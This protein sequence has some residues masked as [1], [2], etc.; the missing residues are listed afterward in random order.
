MLLDVWRTVESCPRVRPIL[1]TTL[2]GEFAI[3]I[4]PDDI[5][6]QG[7]GALGDRLE[8]IFHRGLLR[9][10][11]VIAVGADSPALT[12]AHLK[13]ALEALQTKDSVVGPSTDGGFYLLGLRSLPNGLFDSLPWSCSQ[14][15]EALK[16]RIVKHHLSMEE[17]D[18]LFDVDT[19][20]DLVTLEKHL[21]RHPGLA[22]ATRA[23]RRRNQRRVVL[24]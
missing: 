3:G 12:E 10:P 14:T 22:P 2:P 1:A 11:A 19:P 16:E 6:L 15:L 5:W 21:L 8:R 9:A 4:S 7:K 17:L 20:G 23:W 13:A 24:D 18:P